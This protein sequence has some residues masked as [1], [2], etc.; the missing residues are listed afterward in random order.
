MPSSDART[1][2]SLKSN[3]LSTQ[4]RTLS[5]PL[6][7]TPELRERSEFSNSIL[8]DV[9]R[10]VNRLLRRHNK[11]VYD[12]LAVS[13]VAEQIDALYWVAGEPDEGDYDAEEDGEGVIRKGEDLADDEYVL[14]PPPGSSDD[15]NWWRVE[16]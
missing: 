4:I 13:N 2:T 11:S 14:L 6:E 10:E 3:F 9:I 16:K 7:L 12:A 5:Q 8:D 1:V 15:E